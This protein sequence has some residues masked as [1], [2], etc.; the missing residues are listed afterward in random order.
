MFGEN[1]RKHIKPLPLGTTWITLRNDN[2]ADNGASDLCLEVTLIPAE[3]CL[4]S[5]M[6]LFRTR[7][8]TILFT[9]DFRFDTNDIPNIDQL[10]TDGKPIQID[11]MYVDTTFQANEQYANAEFPNRR[12]AVECAI[13]E[14]KN[15]LDKNEN[16]C[17]ALS[18]P[19]KIGYEEV[20]NSIY[21]HLGYKVYVRDEVRKY[22][23]EIQEVLD[24]TTDDL[25][26]RV[27]FCS[28]KMENGF[29]V[30]C[31][32]NRYNK[33]FLYVRLSAYKWGNWNT[34]QNVI[35]YENQK[36]LNVCFATHC[37][38]SELKAFVNYFAP[39]KIVGFSEEYRG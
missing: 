29:H 17:I 7:D 25:N 35:C 39:K 20:F 9:G 3:H 24:V 19:A 26:S 36:R 8:M 12:Y 11:V 1:Y 2:S 4:G 14:M 23:T 16:N 37:S 13:V 5:V 31:K 22:Y 33:T 6:F 18:P 30:N 27:H 38:S 15:W 32:I 10:H 28:D 21:N 34:N